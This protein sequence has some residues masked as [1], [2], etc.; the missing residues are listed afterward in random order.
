MVL[1]HKQELWAHKSK[2]NWM[3]QRDRNTTFY[4]V[5]TLVK[6][7]RNQIMVIKNEVREWLYKELDIMEFIRKHFNDIYTSSLTSLV[8]DFLSNTQ[9][10]AQL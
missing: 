5:S 9:W 4:H 2:V 3:I 1:G 7:K 6:R 8:R 10:Q